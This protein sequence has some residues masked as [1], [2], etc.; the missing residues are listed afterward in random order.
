MRAIVR[1]IESISEWTGN[2][3]RWACVALV[4]VLVY[5]VM[6]RYAFTAPTIWAHQTSCMLGSTFAAMGWAYVHRHRGHVR[7][8]IFY[9]RLSPRGKAV[10]DVLCAFFLLFPLLLV[11]IYTAT[12]FMWTAWIEKEVLIESY[13]YPPSGPIR[14]ITVLALCLF[15]LQGVAQFIRDL[16]FVIRNKPL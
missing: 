1:V 4:L 2:A 14:T 7:I 12:E 15:M 16:Y 11:L 8:D 6:M 3:V 13:W 5:E 10:V 9:A